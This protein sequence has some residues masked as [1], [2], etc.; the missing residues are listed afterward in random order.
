MAELVDKFASLRRTARTALDIA[1][2]KIDA[3]QGEI[4]ALE[5]ELAPLTER[6]DK[7]VE[8]LDQL[9]RDIQ[10]IKER[11]KE[12]DARTKAEALRKVVAR[13]VLHHRHY[14]HLPAENSKRKTWPRSSL[15][16]IEFVPWLGG[17]QVI[18][19][20]NGPKPS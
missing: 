8:E 16:R 11:M 17:T 2:N 13:T 4:D 15:E 5:A 6:L 3:I 7:I 10:N 9:G 19:L 14:H 1:S 20:S 12:G 18:S